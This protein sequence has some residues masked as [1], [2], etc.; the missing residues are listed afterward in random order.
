MGF[1]LP[2]SSLF[3]S[4]APS[5]AD[6]LTGDGKPCHHFRQGHWGWSQAHG[7]FELFNKRS[8][9]I[10]VNDLLELVLASSSTQKHETNKC[11]IEWFLDNEEDQDALI[12]EKFCK[13]PMTGGSCSLDSMDF[14]PKKSHVLLRQMSHWLLSFRLVGRYS[15]PACSKK[16][17]AA[18]KVILSSASGAPVPPFTCRAVRAGLMQLSESGIQDFKLCTETPDPAASLP[19][20]SSEPCLVSSRAPCR[21]GGA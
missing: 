15:I 18:K 21:K 11:S 3:T 10:S 4:L 1:A 19:W 7:T 2:A 12:L 13:L 20:M 14:F 9:C 17:Q 6:T 8:R 5:N 16:V